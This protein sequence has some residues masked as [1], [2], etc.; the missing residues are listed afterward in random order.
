MSAEGPWC[1]ECDKQLEERIVK[2]ALWIGEELVLVEDVPAS[3]CPVC[4]KRYFSS[5]ATEAIQEL[6]LTSLGNASR[7]TEVPVFSF[8][9]LTRNKGH[10][11]QSERSETEPKRE[12]PGIDPGIYFYA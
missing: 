11:R 5:Q 4:G 1:Q 8:G 6:G 7:K 10:C 3:V 12:K 9:E 2:L